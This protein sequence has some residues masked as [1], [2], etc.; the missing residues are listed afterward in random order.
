MDLPLALSVHRVVSSV[1]AYAGFASM[2]GLAILVLL[3]FAQARETSALRDHVDELLDRIA[4]LESR[5]A[6]QAQAQM[7]SPAQA[8]VASVPAREAA[9]ALAA[10]ASSRPASLPP[11]PPAGVGA[12]A[13]SAATRVIPLAMPALAVSGAG[14]SGS[15]GGGVATAAPPVPATPAGTN[16]SSRATPA[17]IPSPA[18]AAVGS[19]RPQGPAPVRAASGTSQR[20]P[21]ARPTAVPPRERVLDSGGGPRR[22]RVALLL[23]G[24]LAVAAIAAAVVLNASGSSKSKNTGS[25]ASRQSTTRHAAATTQVNPHTITVAVLNGTATAGLAH[26]TAQRLSADGFLKGPITT[27][28]DQTR[29]S[30]TVAYIPGARTQALAVA[31]ALKLGPASLAPVDQGT[32]SV[33]CGGVPMC[34]ASVFVTVGA[35]LASQ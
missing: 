7:A 13:L 29:T 16:G 18:R 9:P 23:A 14:A 24:L 8:A 27:A 11:A 25:A 20:R 32:R 6:R 2:I 35:D 17:G 30:T 22:G 4:G 34:T 3:F 21:A 33:G 10:V 31:K 12:P 5:L 1:G 15:D 28:A 26:R 19:S